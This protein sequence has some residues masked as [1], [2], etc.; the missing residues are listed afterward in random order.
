MFDDVL[1]IVLILWVNTLHGILCTFVNT[2]LW[3]FVHICGRW[4]K[5]GGEITPS[6]IITEGG[7]GF[8]TSQGNKI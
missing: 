1:F 7:G 2:L 6:Q 4:N 5:G 8:Q 3:Y